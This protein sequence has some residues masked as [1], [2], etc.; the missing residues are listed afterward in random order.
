MS[1][2]ELMAD[3]DNSLTPRTCQEL[4][5]CLMLKLEIATKN[6]LCAVLEPDEKLPS[7]LKLECCRCQNRTR[8]DQG[9][10]DESEE[11]G[12]ASAQKEKASMEQHFAI[13]AFKILVT[14]TRSDRTIVRDTD[15]TVVTTQQLNDRTI[16]TFVDKGKKTKIINSVL[17]EDEMCWDLCGKRSLLVK[18]CSN[19]LVCLPGCLHACSFHGIV[20]EH[21]RE[22]REVL[23][24]QSTAQVI[25]NIKPMTNNEQ[26]VPFVYIIYGKMAAMNRTTQ[27]QSSDLAPRFNFLNNA[28][29]INIIGMNANSSISKVVCVRSN[30]SHACKHIDWQELPEKMTTMRTMKQRSRSS[31]MMAFNEE[32]TTNERTQ[33]VDVQHHIQVSQDVS[34]TTREFSSA[35]R[36]NPSPL[37]NPVVIISVAG[38]VILRRCCFS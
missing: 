7:P 15:F 26:E 18:L 6:K 24:L 1:Q 12:N 16:L 19:K 28:T 21:L 9:T 38:S 8:V 3:E 14:N 35:S 29:E 23:H 34:S 30:D 17:P 5:P 37:H 32:N 10:S 20:R 11:P 36:N 22:K 25:N 13:D 2:M 33:L 27:T 31:K 4:P